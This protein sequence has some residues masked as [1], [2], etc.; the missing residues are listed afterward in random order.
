MHYLDQVLYV[1]ST[2]FFFLLFLKKDLEQ[3]TGYYR[4]IVCPFKQGKPLVSKLQAV[5]ILYRAAWV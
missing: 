1:H 4:G 2:L 3:G 5:D